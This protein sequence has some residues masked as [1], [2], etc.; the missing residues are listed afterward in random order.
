[1]KKFL[2]LCALA[3]ILV[4]C[5]QKI[6]ADLNLNSAKEKKAAADIQTEQVENKFSFEGDFFEDHWNNDVTVIK[7]T[8]TGCKYMIVSQF[9]SGYGTSVTPLLKQDGTPD[10]GTVEL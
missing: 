7:D 5:E 10:C 2:F 9:Q 8:N 1:M 4:G 3:T 6:S